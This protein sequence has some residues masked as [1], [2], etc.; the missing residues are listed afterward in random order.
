MPRPA[1][2]LVAMLATVVLAACSDDPTTV[3]AGDDRGRSTT[4]PETVT[5]VAPAGDGPVLQITSGGGFVPPEFHFANLPQ[6]TLYADG[7]VVVPG[8]TTLEYPGRALPNLLTGSVGPD[9]VR[10]AVEA[11]DDA[12][13]GK[14][15]DLGQ[16][17]V[18]DAPTTTFV[19]VDGRGT[20]R[21]D[22]YALDL[23]FDGSGLSASQQ[24]AR[25]RLREL[26]AEMG[27]LGNAAA[28]PYRATAVSVLVRP[29]ADVDRTGLPG[30]PAPA[31]VDWPLADL[32]TGGREQFGGRCL[33]LAGAEAERVLAAAADARAN[34]RWRSGGSFWWL[35]FRPE[36][37]GTAPCADR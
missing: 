4:A 16:P 12:G 13:V 10:G 26:V 35:A 2:L 31:E 24:E 25:R 14:S 34:A 17:P 1:A 19:M 21:T 3:E 8:P 27:R 36:L 30:E 22:A 29:Y 11:A 5:T 28:E 37:P 23:D 33:G 18:A 32:A 20:H 6:F 9:Q 7:R 15:L